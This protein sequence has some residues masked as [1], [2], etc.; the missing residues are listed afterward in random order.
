MF[1][2]KSSVYA[3]NQVANSKTRTRKFFWSFLVV[4]GLIGCCSQIIRYLT[5][6]YKYPVVVNVD[7]VSEFSQTF[8]AVTICNLN[9]VRKRFIPCILQELSY[10]ECNESLY[11]NQSKDQFQFNVSQPNCFKETKKTFNPETLETMWFYFLYSKIDADSRKNYGHQKETF[12]TS[13][14]FNHEICSHENFTLYQDPAFGNCYTFNKGYDNKPPL[15]TSFIGPNGGLQLELDLETTEYFWL[16]DRVGTWVVIHDPYDDPEPSE[17]GLSVSPGFETNIAVSKITFSRLPYPYKDKC[18]PYQS[19]DNQRKCEA[20]CFRDAMYSACSC[21]L[22]FQDVA[23]DARYCDLEND[24]EICCIFQK[25]KE[26]ENKCQCP[27]E[28]EISSYDIKISNAMWP[29]EAYITPR[30]VDAFDENISREEFR[31]FSLKLKVYY[32]TLQHVIYRQKPMFDDSEV[33]SQIGGQMGLWLGVSLIAIFEC[34]ENLVLV[35][36]FWRNNR[37]LDRI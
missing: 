19:G 31:K 29:S 20:K 14:S 26:I 33:L 10:E 5:A 7:T 12:I 15:T 28:C 18:I 27:L 25:V 35:W 21:Q 30:M 4:V 1:F 2:K 23:R 8:P 6:Y 22:P 36:Q 16:T 24:A 9:A 17:E 34:V 13:C 3:L 11:T 32:D 37:I